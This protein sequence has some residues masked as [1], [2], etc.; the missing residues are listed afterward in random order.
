MES[1]DLRTLL[2]VLIEKNGGMLKITREDVENTI[3]DDRVIVILPGEGED[4]LLLTLE[5]KEELDE[6]LED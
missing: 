2:A 4:T 6:F 5:K 1:I 3:F